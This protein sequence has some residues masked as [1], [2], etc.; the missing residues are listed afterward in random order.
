MLFVFATHTPS[1]GFIMNINIQAETLSQSTALAFAVSS[2]I[3]AEDRYSQLSRI[4]EAARLSLADLEENP[5]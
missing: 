3:A 5:L 2:I 1:G 4:E